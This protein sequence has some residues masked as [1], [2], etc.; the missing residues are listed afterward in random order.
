MATAFET[1]PWSPPGDDQLTWFKPHGTMPTHPKPLEYT[2]AVEAFAFGVSRALESLY[3]PLYEVRPR[4]VDG[5]LYFAS[6]PS[7][8]AER[9]LDA[10]L[11]RMR[12]SG[13]RF[14]R[15]VRGAT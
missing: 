10:Q 4:L 9:E 11:G 15:S 13:L 6:V 1:V 5:E 8:M 3:F 14:T 7:E 2:V 12:D